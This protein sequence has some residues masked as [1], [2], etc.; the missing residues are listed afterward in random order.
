MGRDRRDCHSCRKCE[1]ACQFGIGEVGNV[2]TDLR[3]HADVGERTWDLAGAHA[4]GVPRWRFLYEYHHADDAILPA[5]RG[6]LAAIRQEF[7]HWDSGRDDAAV[8]SGVS[9]HVDNH[10]A[11]L[12][13]PWLAAWDS[14][15][16]AI[17]V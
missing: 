7:G 10:A 8:L 9:H 1:R 3:A 15:G 4:G 16:H 17:H 14:D 11:D 5:G 6:V 12:L 2:V 13:E